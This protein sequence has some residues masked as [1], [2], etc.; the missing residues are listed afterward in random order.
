MGEDHR[1][2]AF[3]ESLLA[4]ADEPAMRVLVEERARLVRTFAGDGARAP[5]SPRLQSREQHLVQAVRR[6]DA[7]SFVEAIT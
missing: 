2:R 3:L 6:L 7:R 4:A 5:A 1:Q